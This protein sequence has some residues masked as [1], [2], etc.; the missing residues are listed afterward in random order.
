VFLWLIVLFDKLTTGLLHASINLFYL[1][2]H[3]IDTIMILQALPVGPEM[4]IIVGLIILLFGAKRIPKLAN[5]IGRSLGSFKK[6]RQD[7]E[8]ELNEMEAEA[9]ETK[10]LAENDVQE[11]TDEAEKQVEEATDAVT[12]DSS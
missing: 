2:F 7:I 11:M 1:V 4:L 5:S 8:Q 9:E 10:E 6:G 12:P 3:S